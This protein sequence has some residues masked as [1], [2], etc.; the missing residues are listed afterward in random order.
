MIN[1]PRPLKIFLYLLVFVFAVELGIMYLFNY[2]HDKNNQDWLGSFADATLLTSACVPFFW[3]FAVQPLQKALAALSLESERLR[4]ILETAAEGIV[5]VDAEG[6]IQS[7]NRAAQ[8]IF[9]YSQNEAIGNSLTFLSPP[10]HRERHDD[11]LA[12]YL[13]T[14][15]LDFMGKI[16]ELQGMRKDGTI[17]PMEVMLS[18]VKLSATHLFTAMI[19]DVSEQKVTQQR[20]EH[21]AH[22]DALINLPNRSLFL[23]RLN[24]SIITA[25]RNQC[26]IA[27]LFLD[28][29]GFKNVND[30]LGHH[31]GD[32][33]LAKVAERLSFGVRESDTLARLGGDEFTLILNAA[34]E[35][36]DVAVVAEKLIESINEPFYLDG[37]TVQIGAS[38]GIARY[39]RDADTKATLIVVADRAMYAAKH[40]GKNTYRFGVPV[41]EATKA[42]PVFDPSI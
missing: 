5:S 15:Q 26:S 12:R 37:H 4:K 3:F 19:R 9:G 17:F 40:A 24:Q 20:I 21:L 6:K 28:L 10:P 25:K 29:D 8:R 39:P 34:Q 31:F 30:E 11:F 1:K 42:F 27:L 7:F 38:I 18:E 36:E 41:G 32:L 35:Y 23:D 22:Y 33:L 2:I 14:G 16:V 13:Q